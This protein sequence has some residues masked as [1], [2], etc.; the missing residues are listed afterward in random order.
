MRPAFPP[1]GQ[2]FI[3]SSRLA[4]ARQRGLTTRRESGSQAQPI[5]T[6]HWSQG[7]DSMSTNTHT[8]RHMGEHTLNISCEPDSGESPQTC[9][10][11]AHKPREWIIIITTKKNR[12]EGKW[13]Q[14]L[15][16]PHCTLTHT[17][18]HQG[19]HIHIIRYIL[20]CKNLHIISSLSGVYSA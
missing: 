2:N 5:N 17:N 7:A 14:T 12:N 20:G 6:H 16:M 1:L 11:C 4:A 18:A 10:V 19:T 15:H 13:T 9:R 3:S 8:H